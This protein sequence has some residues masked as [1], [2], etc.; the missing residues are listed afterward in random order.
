MVSLRSIAAAAAAASLALCT[1]LGCGERAVPSVPAVAEAPAGAGSGP[2]AASADAAAEPESAA[3]PLERIAVVGASVSW[4]FGLEAELDRDFGVAA[5]LDVAVQVPDVEPALD[6]SDTFL[7]DDPDGRGERA[8]TRVLE[9]RP[10]LVVA[11][12][13]LFW[14][15]Y[16][17]RSEDRRAELFEVGLALLDRVPCA[18]VVGDLPDVRDAVGPM[19]AAEQVPAPETVAALQE[20][21]LEWAAERPRVTV[22]PMAAFAEAVRAGGGVA[23]GSVEIPSTD[24]DPLIQLDR[25]HPD[26]LG[27]SVLLALGLEALVGNDDRVERAHVVLEPRR[28]VAGAEAAA[29]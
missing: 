17:Y 18:L 4:G 24:D 29:E 15:A 9:H 7:F 11:V 16:G 19:L 5:L 25:L 10:T 26:L 12:D 2:S 6:A 27:T 21:L 13:F 14:F 28:L 1:T 23:I 3:H 20:R 8:I 22:L